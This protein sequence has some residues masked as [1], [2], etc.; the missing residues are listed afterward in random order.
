MKKLNNIKSSNNN[1]NKYI[2]NKKYPMNDLCSVYTH[3]NPDT[4]R[5]EPTENKIISSGGNKE[6]A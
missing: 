6:N 1:D 5:N 4:G 3:Y 2:S